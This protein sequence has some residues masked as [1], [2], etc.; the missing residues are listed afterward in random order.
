MILGEHLS[1][2]HTEMVK[3]REGLLTSL[4]A[5]RF[6]RLAVASISDEWWKAIDEMGVIRCSRDRIGSGLRYG[7]DVLVEFRYVEE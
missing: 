1:T 6:A 4:R 5:S 7:V 3:L 2:A